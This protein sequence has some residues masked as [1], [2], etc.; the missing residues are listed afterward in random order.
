MPLQQTN[1][2]DFA[3][4]RKSRKSRSFQANLGN[5][6]Q[7]FRKS[8]DSVRRHFSH[9]STAILVEI[10]GTQRQWWR[11]RVQQM[12]REQ[13]ELGATVYKHLAFVWLSFA[14]LLDHTETVHILGVSLSPILCFDRCI[15]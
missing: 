5:G 2:L 9:T 10:A 11:C 7:L 14:F 1:F 4:L 15:C 13:P 6:V 12:Q 3:T 8:L